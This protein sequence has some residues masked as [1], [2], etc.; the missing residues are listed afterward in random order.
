MHTLVLGESAA[1]FVTSTSFDKPNAPNTTG[2]DG[3]VHRIAGQARSLLI[4]SAS[5]AEGRRPVA[6]PLSSGTVWAEGKVLSLATGE[7]DGPDG[8]VAVL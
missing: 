3:R 1:T 5:A 7:G 2:T 4:Q 8:E 6:P